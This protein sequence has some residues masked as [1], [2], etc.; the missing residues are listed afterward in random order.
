MSNWK[1][2]LL[3]QKEEILKIL[4]PSAGIPEFLQEFTDENGIIHQPVFRRKSY[5]MEHWS[6]INMARSKRPMHIKEPKME[7]PGKCFFC[8]GFEDQ[9][10]RDYRTGKDFIRIGNDNSWQLRIFPNLFPWLGDHSNIVETPEHKISIAELDL[11]EEINVF[12]S[13]RDFIKKI[14]EQGLFPLFF[15]NQGYGASISHYHWQIG[16]VPYVSALVQE[17]INKVNAFFEKHNYSLF[18]AI[19]DTEEDE[20]KRIIFSNEKYVVIIPFAPRTRFELLIIPKFHI[21][22]LSQANDEQVEILATALFDSMKLLYNK[23]NIDT[24]NI[25]IHQN[26]NAQNYRFHIEIMPHK[27]YAGAEL[28]FREYAVETTPEEMVKL[29]Q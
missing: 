12:F 26:K 4:G 13:A 18:D 17:E 29:L 23:M 24:M 15:R 8:K 7:N 2:E 27:F 20:N 9:T 25:I 6:N 14:E 16:G 1:N 19:I 5:I 11:K 3:I 28:G 10:P 22:S 21:N